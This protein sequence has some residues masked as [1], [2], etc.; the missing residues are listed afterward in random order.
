MLT[1]RFSDGREIALAEFPMMKRVISGAATVRAEEV[2]LSVPDGH[3]I[4]LLVN[5]TPIH[6]ADGDR[7]VDGG[8]HAGSGAAR[9][10]GAV[11]G[12]FSWGW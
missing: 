5:A 1:V 4:T 9:G 3:R 11:A 7:R 2:V 10:A 6:S 8:H 12:R